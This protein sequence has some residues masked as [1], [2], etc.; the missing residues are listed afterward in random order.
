VSYLPA[1]HW[2]GGLWRTKQYYY[3]VDATVAVES[4]GKM[5]RRKGFGL[6]ERIHEKAAYRIRW[7]ARHSRIHG[8]GRFDPLDARGVLMLNSSLRTS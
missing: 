3:C 7:S 6:Q 4:E 5:K 2:G 8:G 1:C